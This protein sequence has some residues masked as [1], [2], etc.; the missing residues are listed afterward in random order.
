MISSSNRLLKKLQSIR[1]KETSWITGLK[2]AI[3]FVQKNGGTATVHPDG[4]AQIYYLRLNGHQAKAFIEDPE[5]DLF[6]YEP[7]RS[8]T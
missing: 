7:M 2:E 6:Y 5:F 8:T 3:S 1:A 4:G